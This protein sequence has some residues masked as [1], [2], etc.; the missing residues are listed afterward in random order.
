MRIKLIILSCA[1][2]QLSYSLS[3]NVKHTEKIKCN[4]QDGLSFL[5]QNSLTR[6]QILVESSCL[7]IW[8]LV[9]SIKPAYGISSQE[10]SYDEFAQSYDNLDGSSVTTRLGI[11]DLRRIMTASADGRVLEVAVGTGLNL[12]YYNWSK[13]T[14]IDAIDFSEPMLSQVISFFKMP[15]GLAIRISAILFLMHLFWIRCSNK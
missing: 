14:R 6:R 9:E 1:T 2:L 7:S 3:P 5:R 12:P 4:C 15:V 11:D 13:V 8:N 10:Q